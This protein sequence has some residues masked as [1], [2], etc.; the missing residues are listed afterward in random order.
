MAMVT[1][2]ML[3]S[4][5]YLAAV[6]APL[7]FMLVGETP[8]G[9]GWWTDLSLALG[10]I[11]LA[12]LGLQFAVTARFHPVDAPYGLDAVLQYHR[13]ISFVAFAFVLAHPAIL[14]VQ[15]P[16]RADMLNPLTASVTE[17]WGLLSVAAIII[18]IVASLWR[19]PL[20]LRY[21]VWRVSHGLLA[22]IIVGSALIHVERSGYY[23][24]GPWGRGL[25]ILMSVGLIGLLVYVRL[26][27]PLLLL[28][29]PY[30]VTSVRPVAERTWAVIAE[31]DGHEGLRFQPGQF[32]WLTVDRSPF[33]VREHPFS[34]SSSA[35][36]TGAY[37]F[38]I[39]ELGDF[40]STIGEVAPGTRAYLDGPY[41][42]FSSERSQGPGYVLIAGGVGISP[43]VSMLRT[44]ADLD[45]RRPITLIYGN[46]SWDEV[47]YRDELDELSQR[48]DLR[49]VHVLGQPPDGWSGE[50]GRITASV[51]D[52]HLPERAERRQFFIC[53]PDPM[54]NAVEHLLL[55][56][57]ISAE[58][59]QI[60]RFEFV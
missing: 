44:F 28:R 53:G 41:G 22:I 18:L 27:K 6:F 13:Q 30:T 52:R 40:T 35:E 7:F 15:T 58:N 37:E 55:D 1:R 51:L 54:M 56:R 20:R 14:I 11:G 49:V 47:I 24:Q 34:F 33:S 38:T 21:E 17:L 19:Q 23:V 36:Q 5:V 29:R 50:T 59:I 8:P 10:F 32:A 60:E 43:I 3:W 2:G 45:D 46:R 39:K 4:V 31:P 9:R 25:W 48:L 16:G 42:A 26:F 57:R 12:M